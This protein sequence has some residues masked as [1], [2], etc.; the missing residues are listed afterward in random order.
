MPDLRALVLGS[1]RIGHEVNVMGV[2][3]S[4]GCAHEM[5]R[6]APRYPYARMAPWGPSIRAT[7][8]RSTALRPIS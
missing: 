6:V 8:R 7:A 1:G 3:A 2:V 5:R 4:L